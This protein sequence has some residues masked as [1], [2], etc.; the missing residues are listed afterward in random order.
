MWV[1][2]TINQEEEREKSAGKVNAIIESQG[3]VKA[4]HCGESCSNELLAGLLVR[5]GP[6]LEEVAVDLFY[7]LLM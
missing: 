5:E 4:C 7:G 2:L 6:V 1:R 3:V